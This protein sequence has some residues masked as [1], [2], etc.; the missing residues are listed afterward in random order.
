M[1]FLQKRFWN[2]Q[3]FPRLF[4]RWHWKFYK[5]AQMCRWVKHRD[6][7]QLF[8][9][10][11]PQVVIKLAQ[12]ALQNRNLKSLKFLLSFYSKGKYKVHTLWKREPGNI[13]IPEE[14]SKDKKTV[15]L[16]QVER[17]DSY[18]T[19]SMIFIRISISMVDHA[20]ALNY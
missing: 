1:V 16:A 11:F 10:H 20:L 18:F 8:R 7:L 15:E 2:N 6:D 17:T 5:V 13:K 3:S 9:C 12:K 4:R 19:Y 14:G